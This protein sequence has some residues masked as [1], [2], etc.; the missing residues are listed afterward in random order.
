MGSSV[1]PT[2]ENVESALTLMHRI[3]ATHI[4]GV[5]SGAALDLAK[6][7]YFSNR[8]DANE[9]SELILVPGTL[10]A[11]LASVSQ[12][13]LLLSTEEESLLPFQSFGHKLASNA[14]P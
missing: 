10:P 8:R 4:I 9:D 14:F 1:Y 6:A 3:G 7:C 5:G 11:T 13:I 12:E 2:W